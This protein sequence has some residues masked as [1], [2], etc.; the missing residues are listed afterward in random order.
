V[1][2]RHLGALRR[3]KP[4]TAR[5]SRRKEEALGSYDG[6]AFGNSESSPGSSSFQQKLA[7]M[8]N[9]GKAVPRGWERQA[10][11]SAIDG[12]YAW[13][14]LLLGHVDAGDD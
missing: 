1:V 12:N 2:T 3:T 7:I 8:L 13:G 9:A 6:S 4:L 5:A 11:R 10:K 14:F